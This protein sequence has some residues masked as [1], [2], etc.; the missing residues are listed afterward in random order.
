MNEKTGFI[1]AIILTASTFIFAVSMLIPWEGLSYFICI[2]LSWGYVVLSCAFAVNAPSDKKA[3]AFGGV[4]FAAIYAVFVN[5]VYF[6]QLTVVAGGTLSEEL[7]S[8]LSFS[9]MGS[10]MF[11]LDL[12]GYGLMA[13]ST[14]LIG[15]S[16]TA[17]N[18]PDKALKALLLV[19]G[20]FAVSCLL[21]PMLNIFNATMEGGEWIGVA[22]LE[23]WCGYFL[24]VGVL[25][26]LHFKRKLQK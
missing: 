2:M 3:L 20:I 24:P 12:F 5:L 26:I 15:L 18:K 17:E 8:L 19:H 13:V 11:V 1:A 9:H 6:T 14:F 23:F 22:V 7:L 4:A 10:W 25:S 21:L 16:F